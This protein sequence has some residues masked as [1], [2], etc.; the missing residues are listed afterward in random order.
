[1]ASLYRVSDVERSRRAEPLRRLRADPEFK[2]KAAYSG[3]P[4][5]Q[6]LPKG[7][8]RDRVWRW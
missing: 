6:K 3:D 7:F 5:G 8:G 2:K 1:V 4:P